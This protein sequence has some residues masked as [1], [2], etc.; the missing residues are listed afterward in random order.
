[1]CKKTSPNSPP[2]AKLMSTLRR[3]LVCTLTVSSPSFLRKGRNGMT[4]R[5]EEDTTPQAIIALVDGCWTAR[6]DR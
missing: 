2:T 5:A 4:K 3:R 6:A 1:M